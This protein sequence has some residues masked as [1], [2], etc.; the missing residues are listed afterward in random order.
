MSN[1]F[2]EENG[3]IAGLENLDKVVARQTSCQYLYS[4]Y[5]YAQNEHLLPILLA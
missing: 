3:H 5:F 2:V 1:G 4:D